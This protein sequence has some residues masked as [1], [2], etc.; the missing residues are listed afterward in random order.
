MMEETGPVFVSVS[1]VPEV[2]NLPIGLRTGRATAAR[3]ETIKDLR[4]ES[5]IV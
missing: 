5:G 1:I 4:Q 2:E 3:A